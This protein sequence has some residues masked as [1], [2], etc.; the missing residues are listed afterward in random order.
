MPAH[1]TPGLS[2]VAASA[3]AIGLGIRTAQSDPAI[4]MAAVAIRSG[5]RDI[6]LPNFLRSAREEGIGLPECCLDKL[7][8]Y[9]NDAK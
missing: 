4:A 1:G 3:V 7:C 2:P 6:L 5:V 9:R 8:S